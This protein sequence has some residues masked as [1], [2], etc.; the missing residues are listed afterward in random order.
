MSEKTDEKKK[1]QVLTKERTDFLPLIRFKE[2]D[3][4]VAGQSL[5]RTD[6]PLKVTGKLKF[7]A[8]YDQEGFLHGKILRS[9]HPHALIKSID[10]TKAE[11][12]EGVLIV[13]PEDRDVDLDLL[14][15]LGLLGRKAIVA[16]EAPPGTLAALQ[17]P[18]SQL[19]P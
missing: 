17:R 15:D 18:G 9:P 8:D 6:D 12:L 2:A 13:P 11:D 19:S 5:T 3:L 4:A 10:T 7:S 1:V 16:A 14:S